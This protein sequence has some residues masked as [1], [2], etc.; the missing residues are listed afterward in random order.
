MLLRVL[1]VPLMIFALC[2]D[3][4]AAPLSELWQHGETDGT[5]S[6]IGIA[7][8]DN[9][10]VDDILC[11]KY[12]QETPGAPYT[13]SF[14]LVKGDTFTTV[15][16]WVTPPGDISNV[17]GPFDIDGNGSDEVYAISSVEVATDQYETKIIVYN[18][19]NGAQIW[20]STPFSYT[21][22]LP[23]VYPI[24]NAYPADLIGTADYEWLIN[25]SV[26]N[27]STDAET[28][29]VMVYRKDAGNVGFTQLLWEMS[30]A[31]GMVNTFDTHYDFDRDGK[32]NLAVNFSPQ[33]GSSLKGACISYQPSGMSSFSE[34]TRFESIQPGNGISLVYTD[35]SLREMYPTKVDKGVNGG[36]LL[37]IESWQDGGEYRNGLQAFRADAPYTRIGTY[38]YDGASISVSPNDCNG[39]GW[40]ELVIKY[41][42]FDAQT[43]NV[44]VYAV[45]GGNFSLNELW[46]TGAVSGNQLI[47]SHWDLN[48]DNKVDIGIQWL[49]L[50][51]DTTSYGT[52]TF[53]QMTG[54]SF[55]QLQRFTAAYPGY[56]YMDPVE[57][58][59][60]RVAG[61]TEYLCVPVD[62]DCVSGGN[63]AITSTYDRFTVTPL[64]QYEQNGKI[65]IYTIP[66]A[67]V[68]WES[69]A[70]NSY[71]SSVHVSNLRSFPSNDLLIAVYGTE[72]SMSG[73][74]Y[75]GDA[76]VYSC[77]QS[78]DPTT[79]TTTTIP[80][81]T[82]TT[83]GDGPCP[84]EEIYGEYSEEAALLRQFRDEVLSRTPEGREM[85]KLYY[86]V[87]PT[88]V[89]MLRS[90]S[91]FK[92]EIKTF[93]DSILP[94]IG[95]SR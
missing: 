71:I 88:V 36:N 7:D 76:S 58:I 32:L 68:A 80:S 25:Y 11:L 42:D 62:L 59:R 64:P 26:Q 85:I 60:Q 40:D 48:G 79:T 18:A 49:P 83:A 13:T 10:G 4:H 27:P 33:D 21:T 73:F 14:K 63:I 86:E 44:S 35:S 78:T 66:S 84:S 1:Y 9:D 95:D 51:S 29:K 47:Q 12:T 5:L 89:A 90:D 75:I 41:Y 72:F 67:T 19:L 16:N 87:S 61:P 38:T 34:L 74:A 57:A 55:S 50:D 65:T 77:G 24:F 31:D 30:Y 46:E 45:Q 3:A 54:S 15:Y 92:D 91:G 37:F 56:V 28:G 22:D 39:D 8:V 43:S 82:T 93:L 20:E 52:L 23:P 94:L 70:F 69:P 17:F 6:P 53:Y 2:A 81:S